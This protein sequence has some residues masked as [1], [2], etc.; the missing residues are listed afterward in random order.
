M[1]TPITRN[2]TAAAVLSCDGRDVVSI[3]RSQSL[4]KDQD[5]DLLHDHGARRKA[6]PT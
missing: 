1:S 6:R 5:H 3:L 2:E 4:G